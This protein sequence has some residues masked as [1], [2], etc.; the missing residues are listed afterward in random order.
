MQQR[1]DQL[2]N[3]RPH[4]AGPVQSPAKPAPRPLSESDLKAVAGGMGPNGGW[5]QAVAQGPNGGW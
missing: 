5:G 3:V 4:Q 2:N 1:Q